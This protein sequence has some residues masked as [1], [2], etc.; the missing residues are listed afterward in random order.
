MKPQP[1]LGGGFT[2]S[3]KVFLTFCLKV[4]KQNTS[5]KKN[6]DWV[7]KSKFLLLRT[8]ENEL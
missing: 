1:L 8:Q 7:Q 3:L 2:F 4:I 5:E 6:G